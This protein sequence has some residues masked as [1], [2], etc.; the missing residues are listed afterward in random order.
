MRELWTIDADKLVTHVFTRPTSE[1]YLER[2]VVE[3]HQVLV[4]AFALEIAVTLS[5]L[6]MI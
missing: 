1:G 3:P 5:E 4:P 2:R 6:P